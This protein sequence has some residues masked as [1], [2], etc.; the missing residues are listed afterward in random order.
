MVG[1]IRLVF[2][3]VLNIVRG[4]WLLSGSAQTVKLKRPSHR[5]AKK[6]GVMTR[7]CVVRLALVTKT[8]R[9]IAVK[10]VQQPCQ[11]NEIRF[12]ALLDG[13]GDLHIQVFDH[14]I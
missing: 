11:R 3:P 5:P 4:K 14:R 12:T 9:I 8:A 2:S 6:V 1:R 7:C 13:Q 10:Q